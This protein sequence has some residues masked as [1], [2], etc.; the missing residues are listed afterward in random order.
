MKYF[1]VRNSH[2]DHT[3]DLYSE[4][5]VEGATND[6][7]YLVKASTQLRI[8]RSKHV[9]QQCLDETELLAICLDACKQEF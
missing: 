4:I 8:L 3:H 1:K 9:E 2:N 6:C 7:G 5:F